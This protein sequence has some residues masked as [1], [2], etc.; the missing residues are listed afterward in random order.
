MTQVKRK[1]GNSATHDS[2]R[3]KRNLKMKTANSI[4]GNELVKP[5]RLKSAPQPKRNPVNAKLGPRN[6]ANSI[7]GNKIVKPVRLKSAPQPK[8]NPVN[9]KLGPRNSANSIHGNELVKPVRL[10][11]APILRKFN[12]NNNKFYTPTGNFNINNNKFYTP[13]G[14]FNSTDKK[15]IITYYSNIAKYSGY[16][17]KKLKEA[18]K[19][20]K[21]S[22]DLAVYDILKRASTTKTRIKN[23]LEKGVNQLIYLRAKIPDDMMKKLTKGFWN[24]YIKTRTNL[25]ETMT[26]IQRSETVITIQNGQKKTIVLVKSGGKWVVNSARSTMKSETG[27]K[28]GLAVIA[29][30]VLS[31]QYPK[32]VKKYNNHKQ[33]QLINA[34]TKPMKQPYMIV[35]NRKRGNFN[36]RKLAVTLLNKRLQLPD[37]APTKSEQAQ[38]NS[39]FKINRKSG[40]KINPNNSN[41]AQFEQLV[42]QSKRNQQ[43]AKDK[44]RQNQRDKAMKIWKQ[45]RANHLR[46]GIQ[47]RAEAAAKKEL[48]LQAAK[49]ELNLQ[50]AQIKGKR[51]KYTL[52][53]SITAAA[54]L[55]RRRKI[56]IQIDDNAFLEHWQ[57]NQRQLN[58]SKLKAMKQRP[59]SILNARVPISSEEIFANF[60][61]VANVANVANPWTLR[62][63]GK[64]PEKLKWMVDYISIMIKNAKFVNIMPILKNLTN[65]YQKVNPGAPKDDISKYSW[66]AF[67][68]WAN[69][70]TLKKTM[71]KVNDFWVDLKLKVQRDPATQPKLKSISPA[72]INLNNEM[73]AWKFRYR[74][75]SNYIMTDENMYDM[76]QELEVTKQSRAKENNRLHTETLKRRKAVQEEEAKEL[77]RIHK[78]EEAKELKRF[79]EEELNKLRQGFISQL[80]SVKKPN[81]NPP[82]S[83]NSN[84]P[85]AAQVTSRKPKKPNPNPPPA[86]QVTS[87]KSRKSSSVQ[88]GMGAATRA[89]NKK[90]RRGTRRHNIT[91][92]DTKTQKPWGLSVPEQNSRGFNK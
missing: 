3:Q 58:R 20:K 57:E 18:F 54:I 6:S 90:T 28:V 42:E 56:R 51:I 91:S 17:I 33:T 26:Q 63:T 7:H 72:N 81:S 37:L 14:K 84:P 1:R 29:L 73:R 80:F 74:L 23:I 5:V 19:T 92:G 66:M 13:T 2:K 52:L 86:A 53:A 11:S 78:E 47:R 43:R 25:L 48:N 32:I 41:E 62:I 44:K 16:T 88:K 71:M 45:R 46:G 31:D 83:E 75:R 50:V 70:S 77:K 9:A 40:S 76:L 82:P 35:G 30:L 69:Y 85:A 60:A 89:F 67:R 55:A 15:N 34:L 27:R 8:R 49:K 12:I 10:K 24:R 79:H 65:R 87:R 68:D 61:N 22:V 4:H 59:R 36:S 39:T 64:L 38:I 21:S